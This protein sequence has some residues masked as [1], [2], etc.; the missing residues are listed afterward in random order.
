MSTAVNNLISEIKL[1]NPLQANFLDNA[2]AGLSAKDKEEFEKYLQYVLANGI[3]MVYLAQS[4]DLIVKDTLREQIFFKR[5]GRYRYSTYEEVAG[6]V[7][8]NDEYMS[9][10]MLGLAITSYLWLNHVQMRGFFEAQIPRDRKGSYL[11]I[12]PGHGMYFMKSMKICSFDTYE[13]IDISPTSVKMTNEILESG[14]FGNFEN[15]K[16]YEEDFLNLN[17]DAKYDSIVMGEVLEHVESPDT[18]LKKIKSLAKPDA[19]I[20]VTTCI[21]APAIDHISLF[22]SV[23]HL[24]GIITNSGL[25][26]AA[27]LVVPYTGLTLEQS[28]QQKL[29]I[30]IAMVLKH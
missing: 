15:Y 7:Y 30:N 14:A 5:N 27:E 4:Y 9:K 1:I 16:V 24:H 26:V 8:L 19:F 12:G 10:Y 29:P 2:I 13:G 22:T 18:F 28:E 3:E 6:S 17:T 21:N 25:N 23:E 20:Y 11:E